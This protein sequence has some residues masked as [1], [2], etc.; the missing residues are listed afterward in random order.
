[1]NRIKQLRE[2]NNW[3]QTELA[4]RMNCAMSSIAMYERGE[5]KPSMEALLKLSEIFRVS[6]DYLLGKTEIRNLD[7]LKQVR[8]ACSGGLDVNGLDEEDLLELQRQ[9]EYM[10]KLKSKK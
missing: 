8:F 1:M 6:T 2:E 7:E 9:V 4:R 10:K 3:T 5:R